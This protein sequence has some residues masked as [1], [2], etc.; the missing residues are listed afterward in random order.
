MLLT[1]CAIKGAFMVDLEPREDQRGLLARTFCAE[2]FGEQGLET[3]FVQS[4]L[5]FTRHRGT[6]RGL[7]YQ[8][9]PAA[10]AKLVRCVRGAVLDVTVDLRP[11]SPTFMTHMA[12]ELTATNRR[13]VYVPPLCAHAIQAL[14]DNVEYLSQSSA[15]YAQEY[16]RGIRFDDPA[17]AIDWPLPVKELSQKDA[18]WEPYRPPVL[19]PGW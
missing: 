1:E 12:V 16:E 8:V 19:S 13:S 7:H 17:F 9:A 6:I 15:F 18:S 2:E 10:E 14:R 3:V 11:E 5:S 4:Y